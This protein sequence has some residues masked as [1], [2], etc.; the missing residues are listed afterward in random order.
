MSP[1]EVVALGREYFNVNPKRVLVFR[2]RRSDRVVAGVAGGL[3][4]TLGVS[5][6][7]VRAAF[8]TLSMVWGLGVLIYLGMWLM[9]LDRVEDVEVDEVSPHQALGL[10]IGFAG[11]MLLLGAF[12]WWPSNALV[13]TVGALAFGVAALT[14]R[15][16]PGPL[17]SLVDPTVQRPGR[18][19]MLLG[20]GLLIGG[21]AVFSANVGPIYEIGPV[22]LAV[23][24]TGVGILVAF[25]PWVTRLARDL[26]TERRERIRQEERAE[27]AAHLHDSVLQ[28]LALIQRS[29]DP[30]R[31]SMLARHQESE[32]RD[33]LYG[34]V[35]MDGVDLLSTALKDAAKRIEADHQVPIDVVVVGDHTVDE[36]TR[37]LLGAASEAMVNAAKHSGAERV[38]LYFEADDDELV[39][40][41]TDQ[42]KGFDAGTVA[43]DRRGITQSIKAR[44]HKAGGVAAVDSEP[45]E[46][47]EVILRMP[48]P[49]P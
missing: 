44:V 37:A 35:P 5:D 10:G 4:D 43:S 26:G 1:I 16:M 27:M 30:A 23:A 25:G 36:S 47:T 42:G 21:L 49:A 15:N 33:W 2:R 39:V 14:D 18:F 20:V 19:R 40:Y 48:V 6:A 28:T 38:S 12:G 3:A 8:V 11:L 34:N 22:L 29:D 41:V 7:F 46:G 32:L 45:G 24:L 13:L 31:M 9:E 17:A